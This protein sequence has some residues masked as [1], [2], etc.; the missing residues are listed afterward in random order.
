M[1][2][3][4]PDFL[5]SLYFYPTEKGGRKYPLRYKNF[6]TVG[7]F[8][9]ENFSVYILQPSEWFAKPG[10]KVSLPMKFLFPFAKETIRVGDKFHLWEGKF[11]A[12]GIVEEIYE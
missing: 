4:K 10:D 12:E 8:E 1:E 9:K 7:M 5:A 6:G 3:V 2:E 11:Y